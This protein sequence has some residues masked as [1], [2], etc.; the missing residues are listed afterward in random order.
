M[1]VK[2]DKYVE[3]REMIP[4]LQGCFTLR[5]SDGKEL[6][7]SISSD[8][9]NT[10]GYLFELAKED[11]NVFQLLS[12]TELIECS[13]TETLLEA[14]L[15]QKEKNTKQPSNWNQTVSYHKN[16]VYLGFDFYNV[17][18]ISVLEDTQK[19]LLFVGPF[20]RRFFLYDV[21]QFLADTFHFPL[22]EDKNY[23]CRRFKEEKCNGYC[24][25]DR[26]EW[27]T[28]LFESYLQRNE[29]LE[30]ELLNKEKQYLESLQFKE[31]EII[32][33]Q[34]KLLRKYYHYLEFFHIVKKM[35][36]TFTS[37]GK[38]VTIA[39]GQITELE[40]NG[41]HYFFPISQPEYRE[42]EH[43]AI[44]KTYL[45]EAWIVFQYLKLQKENILE[46]WYRESLQAL[47]KRTHGE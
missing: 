46:Q 13:E 33:E 24:L 31:A 23:P 29:Q 45:D 5:N 10:I 30:N 43:F 32:K 1:I 17:P 41:E 34:L 20:Q 38:K 26:K 39:S 37:Y 19:E 36:F 16:Y 2:K 25:Q 7:T 3:N 40:V 27:Q 28:A 11:E 21:L 18:F 15:L 12:L 4:N 9:R 35:N 8:M 22:C 44:E 42:N 14:L 47:K 6:Y